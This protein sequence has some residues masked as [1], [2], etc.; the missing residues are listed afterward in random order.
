VG[1]AAG[2]WNE[3]VMLLPQLAAHD[4]YNSINFGERWTADANSTIARMSPGYFLCPSDESPPAHR[5]GAA[6]Y[7]ACIGSGIYPR[8]VDVPIPQPGRGGD[9]LFATIHGFTPS[10][11]RDGLSNT[12]A[13]S[14]MVHGAGLVFDQSWPSLPI[15]T[16]GL[17]YEF[18][19][20]PPTQQEV[21]DACES[22]PARGIRNIIPGNAGTPWCSDLAYNHLFTPGKASCLFNRVNS[23]LTPIT[24]SSRHRNG[25]NVLFADGHLA[26]V[27]NHVDS[28]VWRALGSKNGEEPSHSF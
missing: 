11:V 13:M 14:E 16:M 28:G 4:L 21:M 25:V 19:D 24:A 5:R 9:G 8:G 27:G 12:V 7:K 26:F 3:K 2:P 17:I 10:D 18:T 23:N 20:T 1:T 15:P 6:N 22:L